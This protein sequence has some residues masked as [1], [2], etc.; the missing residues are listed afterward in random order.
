MAARLLRWGIKASFRGYLADL[1]DTLIDLSQGA[2]RTAD[3]GFAWPVVTADGSGVAARGAVRIRAHGGLLDVTL[4]DP[5]LDLSAAA[6]AL[7]FGSPAGRTE[8]ARGAVAQEEPL[9]VALNVTFAGASLLGGIYAAGTP[10]D[11]LLVDGEK[12]TARPSASVGS[13]Q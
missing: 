1:D 8:V 10:I 12:A 4:A 3:G 6:A 7:S 2:E 13:V 11:D 9:V 5:V